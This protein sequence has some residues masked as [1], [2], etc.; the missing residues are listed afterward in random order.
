MRNKTPISIWTVFIMTMV[1]AATQASAGMVEEEAEMIKVENMVLDPALPVSIIGTKMDGQVNFMTCAWFTR[2]EVDPYLFGISIQKQHFTHKAIVKN[3]VFSINIPAVDLIPQVD[4]AGIVSGRRYDKSEVFD[5]FFGDSE[6]APM[7]KGSIISIECELVDSV[8]L[9]E[10]D[11]K[12]PRA[13][14]LF[15]GKVKNVWADRSTVDRKALDL[16]TQKPIFWTWSP[17]NYWTIG[18]NK[19]QAFNAENR[20]L[21]PKKP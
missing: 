10:K 17:M 12:H 11:E 16:E 15:I 20:K 19:G 21:V 6:N 9:V 8:S 3:G 14:T 1:C 4:A 13:H 5:V 2:L 18:E 7:V